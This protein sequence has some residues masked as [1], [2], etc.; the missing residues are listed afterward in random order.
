MII[1]AGTTRLGAN[2]K[3]CQIYTSENTEVSPVEN[4]TDTSKSQ[5]EFMYCAFSESSPELNFLKKSVGS[6]KILIIVAA[7]TETPILVFMRAVMSDCTEFISI[8]P[9]VT[10][11]RN[12]VIAK[13]S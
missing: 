13:K 4:K 6:D 9:I 10:H 1:S 2:T 11:T 8:V 12:A 5:I 3:I 7:C